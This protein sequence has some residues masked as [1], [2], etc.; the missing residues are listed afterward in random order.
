MGHH[1][2]RHVE[3]RLG[4]RV[5][6]RLGDVELERAEGE[7]VE[8]HAERAH[9]AAVLENL[10]HLTGHLAALFLVGRVDVEE[11]RLA[12]ERPDLTGDALGVGERRLAVEVDAEDVEPRARERQAHRL[13]E[14]GGGAQR[15][16]PAAQT[17]AFRG[18]SRLLSV[19]D[20]I[21]AS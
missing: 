1:V 9:L 6:H 16:R 21:L 7:R 2:D 4:H 8:Q 13:A 14:P 12:P 20:R 10:L 3:L 11:D 18:H 17:D 19:D 15:Q 5:L